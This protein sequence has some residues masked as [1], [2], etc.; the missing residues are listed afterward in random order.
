MVVFGGIHDRDI[1]GFQGLA[2]GLE[3]I[4]QLLGDA[5][6]AGACPGVFSRQRTG[7]IS[8]VVG[9]L[10]APPPKT[11][12]LNLSLDGASVLAHRTR[13]AAV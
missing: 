5:K 10:D 11:R 13:S 6:S 1:S 3:T 8:A 2:R 9:T 7:K 4:V 12:I